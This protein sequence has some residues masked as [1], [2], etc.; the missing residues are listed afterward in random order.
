MPPKIQNSSWTLTGTPPAHR[1]HVIGHSRETWSSAKFAR[2]SPTTTRHIALH[3]HDRPSREGLVAR[4]T[5]TYLTCGTCICI[6]HIVRFCRSK[7]FAKSSYKHFGE[8]ISQIHSQ[9]AT[10]TQW[11]WYTNDPTHCSTSAIWWIEG[12]WSV[13][14]LKRNAERLK[15]GS[16]PQ[17]T[18]IGTS[19]RVF[20]VDLA[21]YTL[22][23]VHPHSW[24]RAIMSIILSKQF[25]QWPMQ[26]LNTIQYIVCTHV[27]THTRILVSSP[28]PQLNSHTTCTL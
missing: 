28:D 23:T 8:T 12:Q 4:L 10:P 11:A 17:S 14:Y 3:A 6:Y 7:F 18:S 5:D 26:N 24:S 27:Y 22:A 2:P 20:L 9:N 25:C 1:Q 19:G 13:Y 15:W 21:V 16:K